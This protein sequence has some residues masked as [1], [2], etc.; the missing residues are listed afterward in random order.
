MQ[1][2]RTLLLLYALTELVVLPLPAQQVDA[3]ALDALSREIAQ[4]RVVEAPAAITRAITGAPPA[5]RTQVATT[6]VIAALRSHPAAV[7][8]SVLAAVRA[9]PGST[10]AVVV[11]A[12]ETLPGS[13]LALVSA[14]ADASDGAGER[15]IAAVERRYPQRAAAFEREVALVQ[16]RRLLGDRLPAADPMTAAPPRVRPSPQA[17]PALPDAARP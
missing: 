6:A 4:T 7:G 17:P 8:P 13:L 1:P 15:V 10:E 12:S 9:A 11:A 14:A 5:D 3:A 16:A 2:R